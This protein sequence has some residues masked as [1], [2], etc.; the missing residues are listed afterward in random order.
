[1]RRFDQ[2]YKSVSDHRIIVT[3]DG[4]IQILTANNRSENNKAA[5]IDLFLAKND[6]GRIKTARKRFLCLLLA[7]TLRDITK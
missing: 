2:N 5:Q 7:V 1:L 4:L 6:K 3:F